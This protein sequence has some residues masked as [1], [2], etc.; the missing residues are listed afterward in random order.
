M[1]LNVKDLINVGLFTVFSV[2]FVL[3]GGFI[4]SITLLMPMFITQLPT[5]NY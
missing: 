1:K 2:V 4:G 5:S 3:M